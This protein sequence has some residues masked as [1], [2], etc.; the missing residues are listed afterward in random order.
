M[1][2]IIVDTIGEVVASSVKDIVVE[3]IGSIF[4][5]VMIIIPRD[6]QK[7]FLKISWNFENSL[8]IFVIQTERI[9]FNF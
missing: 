2:D 5:W 4:D 3:T 6:N 1:F 7:N 8:I 9:N